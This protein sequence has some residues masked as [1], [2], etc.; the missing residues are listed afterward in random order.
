MGKVNPKFIGLSQYKAPFCYELAGKH[1]HIIMDDGREFSLHFLDG[2]TLQY[3]EKGQPYIWDSYECMKGDDTTYFVH[4]QPAAGKGLINYSW[5]IDTDARLVTLVLMEEGFD[6]D[7][8][9]LIR[10]TPFFGAIKVPGRALPDTRHHL[11]QRMVGKHIS[12]HYNPGI[13]IQHIYH[14]PTCVRASGEPGVGGSG[15]SLAARYE[16]DLQSPDPDVRRAAQERIDYYNER[17]TYY[18]IYEEECFHI[19]INDHLNLFCF[20]EETMTL[21]HPNHEG[22]GGGILLLQD[23]ER[24]ID[25]GLSF[26]AGEYYM[27]TAYGDENEIPSPLDTAPSPYDWTRLK[28]MPSI[29]WEIPEE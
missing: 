10:T 14:S 29:H 13:A 15:V 22:G 6:P 11:S 1:F 3:A 25:V 23:T 4:V 9:R 16:Q 27:C 8:P 28:A 2:E 5:I 7:V 21:Q 19:W 12:W 20:L 17:S 18:P 24:V 26:C